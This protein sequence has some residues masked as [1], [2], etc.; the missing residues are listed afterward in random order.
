MP[1]Y[2]GFLRRDLPHALTRNMGAGDALRAFSPD[3]RAAFADICACAG[4]GNR[5]PAEYRCRDG[6]FM[7]TSQK[8]HGFY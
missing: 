2:D 5:R 1:K 7:Q 6:I 4:G 8:G 3:E